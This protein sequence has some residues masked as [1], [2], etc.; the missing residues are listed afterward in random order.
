MNIIILLPW[1]LV[2][3]IG[4]L[5]VTQVFVP[6][7]KGRPTWPLFARESRLRRA[8]RRK[9]QEKHEEHLVDKLTKE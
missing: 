4:V 3:I 9:A 8:L 6:I 5:A 2:V 1:L 7:M